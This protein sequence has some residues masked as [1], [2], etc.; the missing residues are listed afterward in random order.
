MTC[1]P[2]AS[3]TQTRS[4]IEWTCCSKCGAEFMAFRKRICPN[5]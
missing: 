1:Q 2:I 5:G 3:Q 4:G